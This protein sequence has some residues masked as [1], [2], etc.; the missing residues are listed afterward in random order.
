M[1]ICFDD[2]C[3]SSID[4]KLVRTLDKMLDP[5]PICMILIDSDT[6]IMSINKKFADYLEY[7]KS[8]LIGEKVHDIDK[9]TRFPYVFKTKQPE[10]AWKHKFQNGHTA[11]VHR[12]PVLDENDEVLYGFGMVLFED[13]EEF[14]HIIDKNKLLE[15]K[16]E[17]VKKELREMQ[18][19]KYSLDNIIGNSKNMLRCKDMVKKAAKTTSTVLITG[20]SGTGM[21]LFAHAIHLQS[22]RLLNPFV[23]VNCAS[24]P[25]DLL[26]SELFGY[27]DGAFTGAKKGGRLG[28]FELANGGSIFLDEIGDMPLSMQAK[29]LRVLQESEIEKIGAS[30]PVG[31]DVRIIAA[32]NKN[33][34]TLM[35]EGKFRADLFFRLNVINIDI[36]PLRERRQDIPTLVKRLLAK[37]STELGLIYTGMDNNVAEV[38]EN[39]DWPGNVRELENALEGALN[40]SKEGYISVDCLPKNIRIKHN[41]KHKNN[42]LGNNS[43][44]TLAERY[45][46]IEIEAIKEA[47]LLAKDNKKEASRLLNISRSNLY[48]KIN[49][50]NIIG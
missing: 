42:S 19:A 10:I 2:D 8:E 1:S 34:Y 29:I 14:R 5:I 50:Y 35:K 45:R 9:N 21:E 22:R 20:E 13:I 4:K 6:R 47:L 30:I 18:G 16:L 37:L 27:V 38:L 3:R 26:E 46:E 23:R 24:I 12:I 48:N 28:K 31:V 32:T 17:M 36:P 41:T 43:F 33:L 11:I 25:K 49:E 15:T 40:F 44:K 39:Y 7:P